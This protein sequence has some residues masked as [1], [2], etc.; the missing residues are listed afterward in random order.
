MNRAA[1]TP[2]GELSTTGYCLAAPGK[3]YLVYQPGEGPFQ[4]QLEGR[5][6]ATFAMEWFDPKTGAAT[7][8]KQV[9]AAKEARFEP[10]F[11]GDAVLY[12]KVQ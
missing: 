10:P 5:D 6:D 9:K 8:G 3:E 2:R 12:L 11:A 4:V 7:K 1:M